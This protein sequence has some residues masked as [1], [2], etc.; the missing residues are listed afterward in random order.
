MTAQGQTFTSL[1]FTRRIQQV[2]VVAILRSQ[3]EAIVGLL[4]TAC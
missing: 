3:T 1:D 2:I 4:D